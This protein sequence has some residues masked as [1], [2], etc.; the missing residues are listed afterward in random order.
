MIFKSKHQRVLEK[1]LP[2]LGGAVRL[3]DAVIA[4][5][6]MIRETRDGIHDVGE[7]RRLTGR[8]KERCQRKVE[9]WTIAALLLEKAAEKIKV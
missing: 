2:S 6:G 5:V 8:A 7:K 3:K 9:H 1:A 4:L